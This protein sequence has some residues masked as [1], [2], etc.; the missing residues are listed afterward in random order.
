MQVH[1]RTTQNV[2]IHYPVASVGDRILAHLIDQ[3]MVIVFVLTMVAIFISP[4]MEFVWVWIITL[5]VPI[6]LYHLMFEIF[7]N[8]QSPGKRWMNIKVM[9]LDGTPAAVGDYLFRWI[10]AFVDIQPMSG[11]IAVLTITMGEKG[12]RLGDMV[13][14]TTVVKLIEER[15]IA[16]AE[17]FVPQVAGYVITFPQV[18]K[19]TNK[20]LNWCKRALDVNLDSGNTRPLMA[21]TEKIKAMMG[22]QTDLPPVKFLYTT[23]RD[24]QHLTAR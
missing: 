2:F 18:V 17:V 24:F 9:R 5:G 23:I 3:L 22:I 1:V 14:G 15:K 4:E 10:F 8:G 21:L 7:I 20:I 13:A 11:L 6:L 16:A 19:L 12:Q